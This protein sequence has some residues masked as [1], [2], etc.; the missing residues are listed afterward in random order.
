ML[1]CLHYSLNDSFSQTS[2]LLNTNL[3]WLVDYNLSRVCAIL[4][5]KQQYQVAKNEFAFSSRPS[6]NQVFLGLRTR[7]KWRAIW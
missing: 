2:P 5:L 1:L 6:E 4:M 7:N 3:Q